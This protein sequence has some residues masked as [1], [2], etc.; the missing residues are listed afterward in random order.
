MKKEEKIGKGTGIDEYISKCFY[1]FLY[2]RFL[3]ETLSLMKRE[4]EE[5]END[6]KRKLENERQLH[7]EKN[8]EN[9]KML[10]K[11]EMQLKNADKQLAAV[12]SQE[13]AGNDGSNC[14]I[15]SKPRKFKVITNYVWYL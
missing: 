3:E 12:A 2:R 5:K 11:L 4:F 14:S 8:K 9:E 13:K 10:K 7:E 6:W 1:L 15:G